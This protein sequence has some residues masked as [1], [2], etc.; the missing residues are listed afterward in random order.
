MG[1]TASRLSDLI[2]DYAL[3]KADNDR[4]SAA[5]SSTFNIRHSDP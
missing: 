1:V 2:S 5:S 4:A 3:A